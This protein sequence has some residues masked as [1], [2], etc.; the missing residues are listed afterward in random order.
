MSKV[1]F[2]QFLTVDK[3]VYKVR[4]KCRGE[5]KP[6]YEYAYNKEWCPFCGL[7]LDIVKQ[8]ENAK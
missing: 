2:G 6:E 1:K 3:E 7:N 8:E 4:P 5:I